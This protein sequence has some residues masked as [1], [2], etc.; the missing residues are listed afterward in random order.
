[1]NLPKKLLRTNFGFTLVELL[2]VMAILSS[3]VALVAG[4]Y[5]SAQTRGTDAQRKADLRELAN[6]LELFYEDYKQYPPESNENVTACPWD[7]TTS[8][9]TE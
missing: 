2:V 6:A 4:G 5:R 9:G 7:F 3:L 8:T 1:M